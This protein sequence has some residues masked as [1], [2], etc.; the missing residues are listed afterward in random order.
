MSGSPARTQAPRCRWHSRRR[1]ARN[2]SRGTGRPR[3]RVPV[4]RPG[5]GGEH[6]RVGAACLDPPLVVGVAQPPS[7]PSGRTAGRGRPG[8]RIPD[9]RDRTPGRRPG[10]RAGLPPSGWPA[11]RGACPRCPARPGHQDTS[12]PVEPAGLLQRLPGRPA[13]SGARIRPTSWSPTS[14][15]AAWRPLRR[16]R[17]RAAT[18]GRRMPE[19]VRVEVQPG[20]HPHPRDQVIGR[21]IRPRLPPRLGPQVDEHVIAVMPPY[22]PCR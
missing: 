18:G 20:L 14:D 5:S 1:S 21:R 10:T 11:A 9:R 2:R 17:R 7:A 6:A 13:L 4:P 3:R 12:F 22:S 16:G 8:R 15:P 19:P